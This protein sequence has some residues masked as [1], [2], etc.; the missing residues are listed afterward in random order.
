MMAKGSAVFLIA[1]SVFLLSELKNEVSSAD[2]P[3]YGR[4]SPEVRG[5][6]V[7]TLWL[8]DWINKNTTDEA[9]VLF[10]TSPGRI[11]DDAHV[12]GYLAMTTHRE[13]IGGPY[14]F[15]HHADF[16][17]GKVFGKPISEF[18]IDAFSDQLRLYNIGWVVAQSTAAVA[19][20]NQHHSLGLVAQ[21][22]QFKIF[23]VHQAHSYFLEGSGKVIQRR[24]NRID[25][26]D[27]EGDAVTLK[28]HYAEGMVS[29]PPADL[30][31]VMLPGDPEPFIRILVPPRRISITLP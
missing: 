6:G 15:M 17:D 2:T 29:N 22:G 10:E 30:Q 28:Y 23:K 11:Y 13:F 7:I 3:H 24:L 25:L 18:S 5:P 16:W 31:P 1:S 8:T 14:V 20:L 12:P 9:R 27:V 4:P 21:H 19:Y 26:D